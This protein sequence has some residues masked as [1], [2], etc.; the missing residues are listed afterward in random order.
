MAWL[1]L[2]MELVT[3]CFLAGAAG[4]ETDAEDLAEELLRPPSLIGQWRYWLRAVLGAS[5][6]ITEVRARETELFGSTSGSGRQGRVWVRPGV[7]RDRLVTVNKGGNTSSLADGAH[8]S[9]FQD[10]DHQEID[11]LAY[12][13]GQGLIHFSRGLERPA[14]AAGQSVSVE[15]CLRGIANRDELWRDLR[16]ALWCWQTFGGLGAR[17]RRGWGSVQISVGE[18]LEAIGNPEEEQRWRE[19]FAPVEQR[20]WNELSRQQLLGRLLDLAA[21]QPDKNTNAAR[22]DFQVIGQGTHP[23]DAASV[24]REGESAFSHIG[25]SCAIVSESAQSGWF[26]ALALLGNAMLLVRSNAPK[27]GKLPMRSRTGGLPRVTDHDDVH[28]MLHSDKTLTTAP[29]RAA[30]GLPHNYYFSKSKKKTSFVGSG[31][32][33]ERRASPVFLH[34]ARV[35]KPDNQAQGY[36]PVVLWLKSRLTRDGQVFCE[37][38]PTKESPSL[39]AVP[40]WTT[41]VEFLRK[42]INIS[43]LNSPV[44]ELRTSMTVTPVTKP[45]A[46]KPV[47]KGQTRDGTLK[48][49]DGGNWIAVFEDVGREGLVRDPKKLLPSASD[50]CRAMFFIEEANK[51]RV[52]AR[53]EKLN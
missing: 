2:N 11:P 23:A 12:L 14:L 28:A 49:V 30:F 35:W 17:S 47:N 6:S 15:V 10:G 39:L 41:V 18:E 16:C 7:N 46:I 8:W 48:L 37:D 36:A 32:G 52:T 1:K 34:V 29:K 26:E 5:R 13:L 25:C 24:R 20:V 43:P 44:E 31:S 4:K 53:L 50:G 3:P 27:Q 9:R 51:N 45:P 22:G 42:L 21:G 19:W 40:N 33:E 38:N